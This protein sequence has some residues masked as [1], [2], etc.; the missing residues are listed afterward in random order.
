MAAVPTRGWKAGA[1]V[2][3]GE[4]VEVSMA[5]PAMAIVGFRVLV[6]VFWVGEESG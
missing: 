1:C 2:T 6:M 3:A 4:K 5:S